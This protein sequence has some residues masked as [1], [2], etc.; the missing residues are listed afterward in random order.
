MGGW[1]WKCHNYG[2]ITYSES[3]IHSLSIT[4]DLKPLNTQYTERL[5]TQSNTQQWILSSLILSITAVSSSLLC[6][7]T[8]ACLSINTQYHDLVCL[9]TINFSVSTLYHDCIYKLDCLSIFI[10]TL[11]SLQFKNFIIYLHH[12]H[13]LRKSHSPEYLHTYSLSSA[14]HK[15]TALAR[16]RPN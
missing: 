1:V 12:N 2:V 6:V 13:W 7:T 14:L 4:T 11:C 10:P 9:P 16:E 3:L 8:R 5:I 15:L